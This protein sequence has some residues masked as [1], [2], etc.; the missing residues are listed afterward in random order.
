MTKKWFKIFFSYLGFLFG[1]GIFCQIMIQVNGG[2]SF[3]N[4]ILGFGIPAAVVATYRVN[5]DIREREL[6][7]N[8]EAAV[9][10]ASFMDGT[11]NDGGKA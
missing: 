2:P 4:G 1:V 5:R 3:F 11:Y 7:K 10:K 9:K 8:I 6:K